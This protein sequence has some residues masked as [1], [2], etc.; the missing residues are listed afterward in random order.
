MSF[1]Q[2]TIFKTQTHTCCNTSACLLDLW[3]AF[4]LGRHYFLTDLCWTGWFSGFHCR[5]AY[6]T[7]DDIC[8][9]QKTG[10]LFPLIGSRTEMHPCCRIQTGQMRKM[11]S[12]AK[13]GICTVREF[14]KRTWFVMI[15][16]ERTCQN[17]L[18]RVFLEMEKCAMSRCSY[19]TQHASFS[20]WLIV[21]SD[22][23]IQLK[24][25]WN[26]NLTFVPRMSFALSSYK[27]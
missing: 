18:Q 20:F 19:Y 2:A 12:I 4:R 8:W 22:S 5:R 1:C 15:I 24:T 10:P 13:R 14:L 21:H 9:L 7:G 11:A 6:L 27:S 16:L 23:Q 26:H 25:L 17:K 3:W